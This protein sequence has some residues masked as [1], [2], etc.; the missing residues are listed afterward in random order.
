[1][2]PKYQLQ[3]TKDNNFSIGKN[4]TL[5]LTY[6]VKKKETPLSKFKNLI[7]FRIT[8]KKYS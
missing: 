5:S 6:I 7:K 1:M 4:K 3:I 2:L 8:I